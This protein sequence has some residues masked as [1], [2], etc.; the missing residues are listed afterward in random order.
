MVVCFGAT[1]GLDIYRI[2]DRMS[3][4]YGWSLNDLQHPACVH[5]CVTLQVAPHAAEFVRDLRRS[6]EF[7]RGQTKEDGAK[8]GTAGIYGTVG[9]VPTGPVEHLLN[10]FTDE[11]LAP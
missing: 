2:K 7:V 11:T 10:I 6:V 3:Q 9:S 5:L 1:D 8:Q 4:A